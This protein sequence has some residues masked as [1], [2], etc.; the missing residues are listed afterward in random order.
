MALQEKDKKLII[1]L[2][3]LLVLGG[4]YYLYDT[5]IPAYTEIDTKIVDLRKNIE[6]ARKQMVNL[7]KLRYEISEQENQLQVMQKFFPEEIEG[8]NKTLELQPKLE[9]MGQKL[10]IKFSQLTFMSDL[11]H[12]GGLYKEVPISIV[13]SA[14][15][16]MDSVIKLLYTFDKYENILDVSSFSISPI[17]EKKNLFDI[18]MQVSFYIF[19]KNAFTTPDSII[20]KDK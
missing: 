8:G 20:K 18:K 11:E 7:N 5:A 13:P 15:M 12:K 6:E 9:L 4:G 14:P 3:V 19:K 17:G 2:I 10:G 1:V 16:R